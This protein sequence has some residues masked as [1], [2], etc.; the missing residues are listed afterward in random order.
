MSKIAKTTLLVMVLTIFSKFL[1]LFREQVLA[2]TYGMG[3][4]TDVYVTAMKIPTILF[5]AI[6]GAI[7]TSLVPVYSKIKENKGKEESQ[8]FIN[9]LVNIV[10][11]ITLFIILLGNIFT[12]ELV[13]I[14]AIGFE[15]QKLDLTVKF[16]KIILWALIFIGINNIVI[17]Y[18]QLN[19]N[20]KTPGLI[21]I[22]YNVIIIASIIIS[23]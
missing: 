9:N 13:K 4:H 10:I 12:E 21:G 19:D 7:A 20:F 5:S 18:L 15:G 11:V 17:T 2:A 14:F 23:T 6:G 22:P 8:K 3:M 1:G 16:V